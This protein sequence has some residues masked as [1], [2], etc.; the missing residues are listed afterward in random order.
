[1]R[2]GIITCS[3]YTNYGGMLQTYAMTQVLRK[4]GH[5]PSVIYLPIRWR[6]KWYRALKVIPLR[7][8][9][10]LRGKHVHLLHERYLNRTYPALIKYTKPFVDK[11]IPNTQVGR[12]EDLHREDWDGFVVG[13]D[14]IWRAQYNIGNVTNTYL[15]FANDWDIKRIA[16]A[17]S[18]GTDEWEL[19]PKLTRQC[20]ELVSKFDYVSVREKSGVDLCRNHFDIK[21]DHVLDPTL[22]LPRKAYEQMVEAADIPKSPGTLLT[23]ILDETPVKQAV[24]EQLANAGS[25]TPFRVNSRFEDC[26]APVEKRIQPPVECWIRG[27][28]DAE[29]VITDSFHACVFSIIFNRPFVVIG[30]EGRGLSRFHSLLSLFGLNDRLISPGDSLPANTIDW[31]AVNARH[32]ALREASI[33]KLRTALGG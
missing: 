21:A 6:L 3:G 28:M 25:L 14:Q 32:I 10:K 12:F 31:E 2:I 26:H 30:N 13:S 33:V 8:I 18:F 15:E 23:Y 19:S 27:F 22:L 24:V 17:A 1:M 11:Y 5:E 7:V 4:L 20:K 29:M 16:Y 9:A